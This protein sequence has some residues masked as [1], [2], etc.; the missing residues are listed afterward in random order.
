MAFCF[1]HPAVTATGTCDDCTRPI[2]MRCTKGTLEGFMCP[3]CAH[4][5]Y[6]RRRLATGLK[7]GGLVA[8]M[9]GLGVFGLLIVG[10]GSER[11]KPPPDAA[12][13]D[14][15]PYI[16]AL[17]EQ[18][19]LAPCDKVIVRKL[20]DEL[21][22]ANR[23]AE[24]VDDANRFFAKCG[25]FPR[26]EWQVVYAL[27]QLGRFAE[28]VKHE[29]VLVEDDPFD[30]DFWWWRGED[31]ARSGGGHEG[32]ALADYRQSFANSFDA[33]A[34]RFAAG[35]ILEVA[36]PAGQPC[37]GV[38][39]L[40]LF[41]ESLGGQLGDDT[42]RRVRGLDQSAR[43]DERRG[44]GAALLPPDLSMRVK[45]TVGGAEGSFAIDPRCGTTILATAFAQ[46]AGVAPRP[47]PP[48]QTA[49][50]GAVQ[51]GPAA[52]AR[53]AI[54][55]AQAAAVEVVIVDGLPPDLDGVLGLSF[56]WL[57]ERT[58][59]DTGLELVGRTPP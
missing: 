20:A 7:V 21:A 57:F 51:S 24:V 56:L 13:A 23:Y 53:F 5:R 1:A 25:P 45:V 4:K 30:S 18:R 12:P 36:G 29:T 6:A 2:C 19:D 26:L 9:L 16:A 37:E 38:F 14:K 50:L 48:I 49:A 33:G 8:V 42:T 11:D 3:P 59:T 41:V 39:A 34:A 22:R 10:K 40:D 17:R 58:E 52:S 44:T 28:A 31:R 43:C 32:E 15:D 55:R 35:R 47:G 27:Q 46:R 54:D